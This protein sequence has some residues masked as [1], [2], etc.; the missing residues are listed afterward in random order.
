MEH[1]NGWC[2]RGIY[3]GGLWE[4][5]LHVSALSRPRAGWL[6]ALTKLYGNLP[7]LPVASW[8]PRQKTTVIWPSH[9]I[10]QLDIAIYIRKG[11]RML[12][13]LHVIMTSWPELSSSKT[14]TIY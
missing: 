14:I 2:F 7:F 13:T 1:V 5:D 3:K 11:I 8:N 9:K 6:P 10:I 4:D 12:N